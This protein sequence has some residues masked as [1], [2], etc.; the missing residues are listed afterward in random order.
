MPAPRRLWA[1]ARTKNASNKVSKAGIAK[2]LPCGGA[3]GLSSARS[4]LS[5]C[6]E[7]A[8][9]LIG[10]AIGLALGLTGVIPRLR[11][12]DREARPQY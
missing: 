5:I 12:Y 1:P 10:L 8:L 2:T 6:S 9:P 7:L 11:R 4:A 3:G